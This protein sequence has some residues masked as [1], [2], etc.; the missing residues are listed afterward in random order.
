MRVYQFREFGPFLEASRTAVKEKILADVHTP[1]H[2][3]ELDEL[4]HLKPK[5]VNRGYYIGGV[6]GI[7]TGA[8]I[9]IVPNVFTFRINVGGRPL[10]SWP[11]FAILMFEL[12]VLFAAVGSI[13]AFFLSQKYPRYDRAI[14]GL[15]E[16]HDKEKGEYFL[17]TTEDLRG[18]SP[19]HSY[20]L[21]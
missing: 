14:F 7:L 13:V 15:A 12:M 20:R 4:L 17:V 16:Y 19:P 5:A 11:A 6:L 21:S 18:S 10:F 2:H 3:H 9:T 1:I 8:L